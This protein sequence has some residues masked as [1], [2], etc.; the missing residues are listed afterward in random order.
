MILRISTILKIGLLMVLGAH[1]V[2]ALLTV[3]LNTSGT[4]E[5]VLLVIVIGIIAISL[6]EKDI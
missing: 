3:R 1:L 5:A 6:M 4:G 2:S